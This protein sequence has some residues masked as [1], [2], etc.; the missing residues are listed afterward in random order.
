MMK[1]KFLFLNAVLFL[2]S[3]VTLSAQPLR[4]NSQMVGIGPTQ[5]LD[6]YLSAEHF[7]GTGLTYLS[8]T[9]RLKQDSACLSTLIEHEASLSQVHD[10]AD[11]KQELEGA[12][13]LYWGK[14]YGWHL[15]N[16]RLHLQAGGVVN[17]SLGFIY[18]TSNS[19]N[20]A[21]ARAA[22]NL[23]PTGVASYRFSLFGKPFQA[24]Y[25]LNLPLCGI[26]FSPHYGQSY[27]E[28][29]SRGDNDH[30]VV[31]TSFVTAP[32]WRQLITLDA[33]LSRRITL[34]IGYLGNMQQARINGLRQH[35]YTHR[36]LI[37]FTRCFTLTP[38]AL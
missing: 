21:Q 33:Q 38:H 24:R 20:P 26:R 18:N 8:H 4:K 19:N 37:G 10:R 11:S 6:T 25:E 36:F 35:V 23:M 7:S 30:N 34:R 2:F 28:I 29:F 16:R 32:E 13:N 5:V 31:A 22:L 3:Y 1:S 27:Y 17:A 15:L 14:L 9:E 12:Y